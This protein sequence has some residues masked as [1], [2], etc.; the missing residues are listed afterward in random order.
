MMDAYKN[1]RISFEFA[2]H[3]NCM[4]ESNKIKWIVDSEK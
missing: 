1:Q 3:A 4:H 2:S